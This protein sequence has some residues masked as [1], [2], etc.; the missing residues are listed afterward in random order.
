MKMPEAVFELQYEELSAIFT[1]HYIV[2]ETPVI[3]YCSPIRFFS[4][5]L[6]VEFE[7]QLKTLY[8]PREQS[9]FQ[10]VPWYR[11]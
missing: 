5:Y 10:Q 2:N 6:S 9:N 4:L 8:Q 3:P 1:I 7:N 11:E